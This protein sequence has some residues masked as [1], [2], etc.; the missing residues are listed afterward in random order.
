MA[1]HPSSTTFVD[2]LEMESSAYMYID[3]VTTVTLFDGPV[4]LEQFKDRLVKVVQASP[5]LAG[6]LVKKGKKVQ[7]KFDSTPTTERVLDLLLH[8]IELDISPQMPFEAMIEKVKGSQAHVIGGFALL[9]KGLP[10]TRVTVAKKDGNSWA[11]IFSISHVVADGYTYYKVLGM[12]S[13]KKEVAPFNP[14]RHHE[15]VPKLKAA[16]GK[17]VYSTYLGGS[18]PLLMNYAGNMI[19]GGKPRVRAFYVDTDKVEAA[20]KKSSGT[21]FVSTNDILTAFWGR[22]SGAH[23]LEMSVNFRGRFPELAADDAG[24]YEGCILFPTADFADPSNIRKALQRKDGKF[25]STQEQPL[26]GFCTMRK[27]KY[28]IITNWSSF[29]SQ[30]DFDGCTQALHIPYMV[31]SE[32]PTDILIIFRPTADTYGVFIVT[33]KLS[34]EALT[35]GDSVMGKQILPP[36]K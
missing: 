10:Y 16:V 14:T 6:K 29:F 8:Q 11:L 36:A 35:T 13:A 24:N 22:L 19:F 2:L 18:L 15:F 25:Q 23:L 32:L 27:C 3:G 7:M 33:R 30:L 5:W 31:P 9:K 34:D 28:R 1:V 4:P 20:K 12:L 26:P 17:K 21:E